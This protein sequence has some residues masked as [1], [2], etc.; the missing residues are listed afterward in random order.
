M[1]TYDTTTIDQYII[2]RDSI[3]DLFEIGALKKARYANLLNFNVIT[4]T[5]RVKDKSFSPEELKA[6]I[7]Q[8]NNDFKPVKHV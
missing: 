2:L 6:L 4:F 7:D 3:I 8:I 5:K 1:I